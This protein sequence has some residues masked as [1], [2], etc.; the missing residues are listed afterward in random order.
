VSKRLASSNAV[1][2]PSPRPP[3]TLSTRQ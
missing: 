3:A 1:I 2:T